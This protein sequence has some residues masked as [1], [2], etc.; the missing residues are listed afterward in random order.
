MS[1]RSLSVLLSVLFLAGACTAERPRPVATGSPT[2]SP[3]AT[4]A[5]SPSPAS[6][7]SVDPLCKPPPAEKPGQSKGGALPPAIARIADQVQEVRDLTFKRPVS[8]EA[9]TPRQLSKLVAESYESQYPK[10][11]A[12]SEERALITIGA[13]PAGTDL[14][15]AV[16][17]FGASQ[18]LGF[19]DT[20]THRLVFQSGQRMSP[21]AKFT[22]AH[23]LTHALQDQ[24]F[25]LGRLDRLSRRCQDDRAEAF[26]SVIEGDAVISQ[27]QWA[28]ANLSQEEIIEI[29]GEA[30]RIPPPPESVPQFVQDVFAFPYEAGQTFVQAILARG[31]LEALDRALRNPPAST[32]QVLHPN[33]YPRDVPQDVGAP[34]VSARLGAGWKAIDSSD[35]G[36]GFLRVMLDLELPVTDAQRAAAGWDGGQYRAFGKGSQ[37]AVLLLTVW[38]TE[39]DAR[40][41]ADSMERWVR[42]RHGSVMRRGTSLTVLFASDEETLELLESAV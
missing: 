21:L 17:D 12:A 41:F 33:R 8:P 25:G 42:D 1:R 40:E 26:L 3:S 16:L 23:E 32:E 39:R 22:L 31:G 38:D 27:V 19:Y 2:P 30:S 7:P 20:Q 35:V 4:P 5:A 11:Q 28:R 15:K 9:L 18:I 29:Q 14:H 37:T 36:E 10:D 13:L 34:D 6:A 24:N